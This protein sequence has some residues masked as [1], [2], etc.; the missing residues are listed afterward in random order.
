VGLTSGTVSNAATVPT[1][2]DELFAQG[3]ITAPMLGVFFQPSTSISADD[4]GELS[5]GDPD[6]SKTTSPITYVSI[7]T[8][9]PASEYWG[10]DQTIEYGSTTILAATAGIVDTGSSI[11]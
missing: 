7:T 8:T 4:A 1:V 10:I 9:S 5:F 6:V 3:S 11:H 2:V